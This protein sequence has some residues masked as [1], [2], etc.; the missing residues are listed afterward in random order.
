METKSLKI[1]TNKILFFLFLIFPI[2]ILLG[3]LIVNINLILISI[4]FISK[5]I[6][7][8]E[9]LYFK[10]KFYFLL[11]FFFFTLLINLIFSN[12]PELSYKRIIKIFFI[13]YFI[14]AFFHLNKLYSEKIN[15]IFK[16]WSFIFFFIIFDLFIEYIFGSNIIG[17]SSLNQSSRLGSF[18]GKESNIGNY[19]WGFC[20][21]CLCYLYN[22]MPRNILINGLF[23]ISFIIISFLIGERSNFIKTF[24]IITVFILVAYE[25]KLRY[26]ILSI[27]LVTSI[28]FILVVNNENLKNRF[29]NQFSQKIINNGLV[30]YLENSIYGAHYYLAYE[31]FKDNKIFGVG[32]KNFRVESYSD[33]YKYL[34]HK[35]SDRKGST[36]PHQIHME[37]LS[38]TGIFG[39]ISFLIF[40]IL[41]LYWSI[42]SYFI[43]KNKY[44]LASILF[45]I[46]SI[47]PLIPSGSFFTT[48]TSAIFWVNYSI[49][50][51]FTNAKSFKA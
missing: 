27:F 13:I 40:V 4:L 35:M 39:Y 38:E 21:L 22:N 44:L 49:L 20:L 9:P 42:K 33:K 47:L 50:V 48:Y 46:S 15:F 30:H 41:S 51:T 5:L 11:I 29:Y 2:S 37:F 17:L 10:N 23:A 45:F 1:D 25:M 16:F 12:N 3:N 18:T 31:I 34:D 32:I 6:L 19:F 8:K 36:H 43:N 26:K 24:F 7:K 28:I 14:F